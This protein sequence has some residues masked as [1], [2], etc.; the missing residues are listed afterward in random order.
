YIPSGSPII[1]FSALDNDDTIPDAFTMA[2]TRGYALTVVSPSS[3]DLDAE[4]GRFAPR[5]ETSAEV[6]AKLALAQKTASMERNN[7]IAELRS[8]GV[9][10]GDWKPGDAVNLALAGVK[11]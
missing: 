8:W 3:L 7:T 4:L 11:R 1:L 9:Y 2:L 6:H 5:P 10:L